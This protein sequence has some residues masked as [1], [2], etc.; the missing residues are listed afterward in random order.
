VRKIVASV[1]AVLYLTRLAIAEPTTLK[2]AF[3]APP[4][5]WV[6]TM[7][8]EPWSKDVLAAANGSLDIKFFYG[9]ALGNSGNIY[10][11]VVNGVVEIGFGPFGDLAD[12]FKKTTVVALPFETKNCG[13]AAIALW[14]L[15]KAGVIADEYAQVHPVAIFAFPDFVLTSKKPIATLA[16]LQGV[17]IS[18]GSRMVAQGL[19]LLGGVPVTLKS[20]EVYQAVQR[21]LVSG[22]ISSWAGISVFKVDELTKY[23]L[24]M[25]LGVGPG[26]FF[27]NKGVYARL[28]AEAKRALDAH[29]DEVLSERF[30]R[31]CVAAGNENRPNLIARGHVISQLAPDEAARWK[32]RVAPM[33]DEWV[34]ATTH[35]AET[36]AAYRKEVAAAASRGR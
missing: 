23:D 33:I 19:T 27:M 7:V 26:Y 21:D 28:P 2:F 22:M 15:Y 25:P 5:T 29:S 1:L 12:Q 11:R 3:T 35:G 10:D 34:K 32:A 8:A 4:Q 9:N 24:D 31:A 14:R 17:K 36:L 18:A 30:A 20:S 6:N 13:E 16:D